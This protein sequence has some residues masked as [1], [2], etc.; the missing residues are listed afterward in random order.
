VNQR[1]R[2][3]GAHHPTDNSTS[4][5]DTAEERVSVYELLYKTRQNYLE[6][7]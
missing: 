1:T 3:V 5:V 4:P 7:M 6:S 2:A